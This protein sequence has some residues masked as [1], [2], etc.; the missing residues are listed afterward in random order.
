VLKLTDPVIS[1][2]LT[3]VTNSTIESQSIPNVWK[4]AKILPL[5]KKKAKSSATNYCL[6]SNLPS[7]SKIMEEM[8]RQQLAQYGRTQNIIPSSQ[9]GFQTGKST[10]TALGAITHDLKAGWSR[11]PVLSLP[12]RGPVRLPWQNQ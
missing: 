11:W 3:W 2:P 9:H 6:V 5:H 12:A 8:V 1:A 4:R 10:I 7:C